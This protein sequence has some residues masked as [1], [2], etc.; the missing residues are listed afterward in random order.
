MRLANSNEFY[1]Y[2]NID[3]KKEIQKSKEKNSTK[4]PFKVY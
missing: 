1:E 4:N 2:L 3:C